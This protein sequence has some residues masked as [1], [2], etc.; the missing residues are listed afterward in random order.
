MCVCVC[1]G[2]EGGEGGEVCVCVCVCV[3][4]ITNLLSPISSTVFW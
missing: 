2:R 4:V 3:C 1:D